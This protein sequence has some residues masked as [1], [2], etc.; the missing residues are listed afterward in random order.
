MSEDG[1][2]I[3]LFNANK[4][5]S[6]EG[7]RYFGVHAILS[8]CPWAAVEKWADVPALIVVEH[9]ALKSADAV[10]VP[11]GAVEPAVVQ[12]HLERRVP[13]REHAI[14]DATREQHPETQRLHAI[15]RSDAAD[16][17]GDEGQTERAGITRREG[18]PACGCGVIE[19][20]DQ[21]V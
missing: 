12:I 11:N 15:A 14:E 8:A 20:I 4:W 17:E 13:V 9:N 5:P 6:L 16:N 19:T 3:A 10:N 18:V 7:A 21:A 2:Q 1:P